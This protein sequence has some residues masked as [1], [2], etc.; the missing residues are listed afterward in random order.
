M[1]LNVYYCEEDNYS[2]KCY[3]ALVEH[4]LVSLPNGKN[5]E[6]TCEFKPEIK[7]HSN[8]VFNVMFCD[9]DE[10]LE[11]NDRKYFARTNWIQRQLL[12]KQFGLFWTQKEPLAVVAII[13]S[14]LTLLER[15]L[16]ACG[17]LK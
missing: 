13:I 15:V 5:L 7:G 9:K 2:E 3:Q 4:R 8:G 10:S 11:E 17:V 16:E 6:V 14:I 12:R 1:I